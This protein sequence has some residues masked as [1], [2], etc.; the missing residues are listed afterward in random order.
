M[1]N[2]LCS[3]INLTLKKKLFLIGSCQLQKLVIRNRQII[4]GIKILQLSSE[5]QS[6]SNG[7]L[8][9]NIGKVIIA[10]KK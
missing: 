6:K 2:I 4:F 9:I 8:I 3:E 7:G 5:R 10:R 1:K